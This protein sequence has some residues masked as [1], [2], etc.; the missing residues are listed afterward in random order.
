MNDKKNTF[1]NIEFESIAFN[2]TPSGVC[3]FGYTVYTQ[4]SEA[5]IDYFSLSTYHIFICKTQLS[6]TNIHKKK[7]NTNLEDP[8]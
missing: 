7:R 6:S 4:K 1:N 3:Q 2:N 5:I 8:V